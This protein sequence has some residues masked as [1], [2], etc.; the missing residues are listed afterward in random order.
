MNLNSTL[1]V[2]RGEGAKVSIRTFPKEYGPMAYHSSREALLTRH[3][4]FAL[5]KSSPIKVIFPILSNYIKGN[6]CVLQGVLYN[7]TSWLQDT[8]V[9]QKMDDDVWRTHGK[10]RDVSAMQKVGIRPITVADTLA[11]FILLTMGLVTSCIAFAFELV[12]VVIYRLK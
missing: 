2:L 11:G 9:I 1:R 12:S 10:Y 3:F 8:G 7:A 5:P 4:S 6:Q